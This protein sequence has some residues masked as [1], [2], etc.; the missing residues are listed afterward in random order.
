MMSSPSLAPI[1]VLWVIKAL[2]PGGAEQLLLSAAQ[3]HDRTEVDLECAY[4]IEDDPSF[5]ADM[6]ANGVPCHRVT[7]GGMPYL[8]P[9]RLRRLI[10]NG[11][12]DI[13]HV[14]SPLPGSVARL[15]AM[16]VRRSLRPA[17]VTTEHCSWR[18]YH[19]LTRA[20]N[21]ATSGLAAVI[22]AVSDETRESIVG[23]ARNRTQTLVHGIDL[24]TVRAQGSERD[25]VRAELG[26]EP[27]DWVVGIVANF[28][29]QKDYPNLLRATRMLIDAGHPVRVVSVGHGPLEGE[30]RALAT[31]MGLDDRMMFLGRRRDATR[32]MAGFDVFTLASL[33]EGLPVAIM[34]ALALGLPIVATRVGGMEDALRDEPLGSLVPPADSAALAAALETALLHGNALP[35]TGLRPSERADRYDIRR[36]A[37]HLEGIYRDVVAGRPA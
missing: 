15:G 26:L 35:A 33:W 13:V 25:A 7:A 1:R 8:W 19:P 34:E 3:V 37:R 9:W 6:E 23:R 36:A 10:A 32:I 18:S 14:H 31:E 27:S 12:F 21:R 24:E 4:L 28:R 16:T 20:F 5:V 17:L 2:G 30:T 11:S 29:E 22:L